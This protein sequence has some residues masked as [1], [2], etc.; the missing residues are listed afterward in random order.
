M[1]VAPALWTR[2]FIPT[3]RE[4]PSDVEDLAARLLIRAGYVRRLSRGEF[5]FLP[6]GRRSLRR[7]VS[8]IRTELD[9]SGAQE[10]HAPGNL[11]ELAREIQSHKLLPQIWYQFSSHLESATL[12]AAPSG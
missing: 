5:A 4:E 7:I 3:L 11:I 1:P 10:F 12:D 6:L 8:L 9:A 2:L